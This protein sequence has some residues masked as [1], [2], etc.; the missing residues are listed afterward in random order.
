M[1]KEFIPKESLQTEKIMG[2]GESMKDA[3]QF[4]FLSAPLSETQLKELIQIPPG[5]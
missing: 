1:L 4:K 2:L 5:S 3:I